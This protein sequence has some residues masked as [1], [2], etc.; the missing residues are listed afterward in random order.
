M[1]I[2][3][4]EAPTLQD[5]LDK[6]RE[7]LGENA[8]VL[9]TRYVKSGRLLGIRGSSKVELTAAVPSRDTV[10]EAGGSRPSQDDKRVIATEERDLARLQEASS[11]PNSSRIAESLSDSQ[12]EYS[13]E[14]RENPAAAEIADIKWELKRLGLIVENLLSARM[15]THPQTS[16]YDSPSTSALIRA[17]I[18]P[19]VAYGQLAELLHVNDVHTLTTELAS[20]LKDFVR[21]FNEPHSRVI[22]LVGPT[23][24]GKTTTLAKLAAK[25]SIEYGEDVALVTIDTYRIGAVD[26]LQTYARIMGLPLEVVMSPADLKAA[27]SKHK[28]RDLVLIDTVGRSHRSE[29]HLREM[30]TFFDTAEGIETHLVISATIA[31]DVQREVVDR[32]AIFSPAR[33]IITKLDEASSSGILVNLPLQSGLPIS[34]FTAGQNVPN[35]L[36]IASAK[37]IAAIVVEHAF[38]E[39]VK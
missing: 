26:Q 5:A 29:E 33:L 24:V 34:C 11:T 21:P 22:A 17:G 15:S 27:I 7:E 30:K 13:S 32:F 31:A 3:T 12:V 4:F 20:K 6:A 18:E 38:M 16:P 25:H 10:A 8:V 28:H 14:V 19:S 35:D 39:V 36:R 9:N 1:R 37:E 2:K 23:G